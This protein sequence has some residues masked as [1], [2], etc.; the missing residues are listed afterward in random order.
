[1]ETAV[2]TRLEELRTACQAISDSAKRFQTSLDATRNAFV[3]A[4]EVWRSEHRQQESIVQAAN[5]SN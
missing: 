5:S 2:Q 4:E 1:M 3:H